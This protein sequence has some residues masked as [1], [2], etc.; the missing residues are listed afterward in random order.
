ME[1]TVGAIIFEVL[2][3]DAGKTNTELASVD[4]HTD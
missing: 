4:Q 2:E 1:D 3:T